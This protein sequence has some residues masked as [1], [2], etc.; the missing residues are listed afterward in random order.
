MVPHTHLSTTSLQMNNLMPHVTLD[1]LGLNPVIEMPWS[2]GAKC[3]QRTSV[4]TFAI[5][6]ELQ[7]VLI[8]PFCA[9]CSTSR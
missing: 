9:G 2:G 4:I 8:F 1:A 6:K 5:V 7:Q 3:N